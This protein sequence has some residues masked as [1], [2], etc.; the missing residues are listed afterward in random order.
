MHLSRTTNIYRPPQPPPPLPVQLVKW[1]LQ[2][3]PGMQNRITFF[4]LD[5]DT[6]LVFHFNAVPDP[7][8]HLNA[9]PNPDPAPYQSDS[10]VQVFKV[11]IGRILIRP[12]TKSAGPTANKTT[13]P[14][15]RIRIRIG[16]VFNQASG[17]GSIFGIRIQEGNNNPQK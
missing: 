6:D 15:L 14:G 17:S 9:D 4:C 11:K 2:L 5:S 1:R 16:S 12:A 13:V 10:T 3:F 8:F 7:A